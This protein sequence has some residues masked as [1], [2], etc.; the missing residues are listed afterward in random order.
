MI[1]TGFALALPDGLASALV[2][3]PLETSG[4]RRAIKFA[5]KAA[6]T[7]FGKSPWDEKQFRGGS[8]WLGL[9]P[10]NYRYCRAEARPATTG[11]VA[12]R[13]TGS[14]FGRGMAVAS[15]RA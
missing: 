11:F 7:N 15:V 6:P 3:L 9:K 14:C 2:C 12:F 8:L 4:G 1:D 5:A 13:S 10:D